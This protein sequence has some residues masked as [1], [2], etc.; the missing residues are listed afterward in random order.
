[1]ALTDWLE[2]ADLSTVTITALTVGSGGSL[3]AGSAQNIR[4]FIFAVD[5]EQR[6]EAEDIRPIWS[7]KINMVPTGE[8][9][10]I[11]LAVLQRGDAAN[12]MTSITRPPTNGLRYRIAWTQ[13]TETF[14]GDYLLVGGS[15]GGVTQR[16][17]NTQ[18]YRF[19]PIDNGGTQVAYSSS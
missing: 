17:Q 7:K 2:G 16:G 15:P 4:A 8:G 10:S 9:E 3:S 12:I 18:E 13:G 6:V 5:P 19:D 14:T 1:M 11:R